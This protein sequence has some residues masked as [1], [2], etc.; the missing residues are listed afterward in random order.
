MASERVEWVRQQVETWNAGDIDG[1]MDAVSPEFEFTPDP[2][3][4]DAGTYRGEEVRDFNVVL[5]FDRDVDRPTRM[6]AFFD[7]DRALEVA[8]ESTG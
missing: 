4:P 1:F 5:W 2:S 7:R 3:F 8:Q 6:A